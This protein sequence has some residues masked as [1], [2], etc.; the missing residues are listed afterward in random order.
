MYKRNQ[1]CLC[2]SERIT[3][4][5]H[6]KIS[7]YLFFKTKDLFV[8][9]PHNKRARG[10]KKKKRA[11]EKKKRRGQNDYCD[12]PKKIEES[13]PI[14]HIAGHAKKNKK[15]VTL[16]VSLF[17]RSKNVVSILLQRLQSLRKTKFAI[18]Q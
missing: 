4:G 6:T 7:S 11:I 15:H 13:Y 8:L 3:R 5:V 16:S 17:I 2:R 10:K 12:C 1:L 9:V 18:N 14:Q